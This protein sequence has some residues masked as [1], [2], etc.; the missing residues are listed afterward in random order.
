MLLNLAVGLLASL[1]LQ[2]TDTTVSV[3]AAP[4][5]ELDNFA[6][7]VTITAWNRSEVSVRATHGRRD[8]VEVETSGNVVSVRASGRRGPPDNV[9]YE[10]TVP[11]A[12]SVTISGQSGEVSV[13]GTRG[14]VSV[15]TVEGNITVSDRCDARATSTIIGDITAGTFAAAEGAVFMGRS[16][17]GKA[18]AS[19]R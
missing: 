8:E 5:L 6:G 2:Q 3:G 15:E 18:A 12:A 13:E 10:I 14:E 17:V 16:R 11:L 19:V 9:D 1:A 4:R 7:T